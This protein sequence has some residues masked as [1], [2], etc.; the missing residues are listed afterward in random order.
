MKHITVATYNICHGHYVDLDWNKLAQVILEA[1]ADIVGLQ[2]VDM[3]TF[4]VGGQDSLACLAEAAG[5]LY[6][7]FVPAM[8]FDGG[9][10]G[11]AILS[12]FPMH[13]P[14]FTALFSA[15]CEPRSFGCFRFDLEDGRKGFF[16]NT[17]LSYEKSSVR[18][19][20]IN[21]LAD[22]IHANIEHES[23]VILTGDFNTELF[24]QFRGMSQRG[25]ALLNN[26][27]TNIK[28]FRTEPLA[29]DNILYRHAHLAPMQYG[30]IDSDASDH[31][32][33]WCRFQLL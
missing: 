15:D 25:M 14:E 13:F 17:H 10:Y 28:T 32:L 20:Q 23:P 12:R 31:N 21:F 26:E 30:V 5:Y 22:W 4:R 27:E 6:Y 7:L 8:D 18:L 1:D 2:E 3:R 16:L 29:I 11:T 33:L 19:A 9:M 24:D